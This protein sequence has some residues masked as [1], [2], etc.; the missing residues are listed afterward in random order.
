LQ[1]VP[2]ATTLAASLA[3]QYGATIA[4]VL[5]TAYTFAV[6]WMSGERDVVLIAS[7]DDSGTRRE[8]PLRVRSATERRPADLLSSVTSRYAAARDHRADAVRI[9]DRAVKDPR[10]DRLL[11]YADM[12][13]ALSQT[14]GGAVSDLEALFPSTAPGLSAVLHLHSSGE[15]PPV[16]QLV[17]RGVGVGSLRVIAEVMDRALEELSHDE[18]D[19]IAGAIAPSTLVIPSASLAADTFAFTDATELPVG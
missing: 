3:T 5:L 19:P 16:C 10:H 6:S 11:D 18:A 2:I 14:S 13:F 8:F 4:D 15:A 1:T 9:A 17:S 12:G 7:T